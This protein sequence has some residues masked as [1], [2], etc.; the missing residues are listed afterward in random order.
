MLWS[1]SSNVRADD[2]MV[3]IR[4]QTS[5]PWV[6]HVP[7]LVQRGNFRGRHKLG[8]VLTGCLPE[9]ELIIVLAVGPVKY[10]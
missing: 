4:G 9:N 3:V 10:E 2:L 1:A 5:P 6:A 7:G 8:G